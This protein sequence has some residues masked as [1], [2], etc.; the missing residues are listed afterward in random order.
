MGSGQ[1]K[2]DEGQATT[3]CGLD[4]ANE[5]RELETRNDVDTR[6]GE[7]NRRG[8]RLSGRDQKETGTR[9]DCGMPQHDCCGMRE[10]PL[11]R[12]LG[13]H[14]LLT[15]STTTKQLRLLFSFVLDYI[16]VSVCCSFVLLTFDI[17]LGPCHK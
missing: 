3:L 8:E 14:L 7:G 17:A 15:L 13:M 10:I 9:E 5:R 12:P 6:K 2:S 1:V 4:E 16:L 11:R